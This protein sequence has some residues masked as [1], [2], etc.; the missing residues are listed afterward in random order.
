MA[1]ADLPIVDASARGG[2][3]DRLAGEIGRAARQTGFFHLTGHGIPRDLVRATFGQSAA[4]F[5]QDDRAKRQL[6]ALRSPHGHGYVPFQAERL[7][8][9]RPG[10]LREAFQIGLE[11]QEDH[12]EIVRGVPFRSPN[13]WPPARA[14]RHTMQA[15][16]WA[17]WS[18]G[19]RLHAAIARD[20]AMPAGFFDDKFDRPQATLRLLHYVPQPADQ[21]GRALGAGEHSDPNSL[22]LTMSD[23]STGL[24]VRGPDGAWSQV[25][26]VAGAFVVNVGD[27]LMR[28]TNDTYVSATHRVVNRN[29]RNRH[30]LAFFLDPNPEA[31]IAVLPT[32]IGPGRP[33]RYAPTTAAAHLAGRLDPPRWLA[34]G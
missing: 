6:S 1:F 5:A 22:T 26:H 33:A 34:A 7:D 31:D 29:A 11:L 15:Y 2:D 19:R 16:F 4:F 24:E 23:G 28:W 30:A 13:Q 18:L 27:R 32:C 10:D 17:C 9:T 3:V 21:A 14:F 20:L 25:P 12:P 8:P